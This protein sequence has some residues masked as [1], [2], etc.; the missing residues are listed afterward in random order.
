MF[1]ILV[2][3]KFY[4]DLESKSGQRLHNASLLKTAI[5][6]KVGGDRSPYG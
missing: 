2:V 5:V 1:L 3:C 4:D 6:T